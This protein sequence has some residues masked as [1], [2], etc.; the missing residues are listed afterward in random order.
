MAGIPGIEAPPDR[1]KKVFCKFCKYLSSA[2]FCTHP[3][4]YIKGQDNWYEPV[5]SK[6]HHRYP[7]MINR[8]NDCS[9]Y[10]EESK[11][12]VLHEDY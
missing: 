2:R 4:N 5:T 12:P 6:K 9:W 8:N 7:S 3:D 11:P 10:E 1:K